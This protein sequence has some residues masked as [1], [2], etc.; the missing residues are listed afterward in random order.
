MIH[1]KP[2][3]PKL[4]VVSSIVI[5][6]ITSCISQKKI[7]YL[8]KQSEN[9]TTS[10]YINKLDLQYK[11]QPKDNLFIKINSL[12]EKTYQF[13]N[14]QGGTSGYLNDFNS[15]ASIYLNSYSVNEEGNIDLPILGKIRVKGLTITEIKDTIQKH[16]DEY[17]KQTTVTVKL[18]NFNITVI[19]EVSRPGE[20]KIYQDR[21]NL[22]EAISLAGDM[23]DYANRSQ[24]QLI[25]Q[26]RSGSKVH[27]L[28]LTSDKILSSEYFYLM[29]NDIVYISPLGLKR[30]GF[31]QF[32]YSTVLTALTALTSLI[33]VIYTIKK[34]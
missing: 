28:D 2:L 5:F 25:R 18:V 19:G 13:F 34:L 12:D 1:S 23:S 30:Y 9:D 21:I 29:P 16:I 24:V 14:K 15:D 7:L 32:P 33:L 26:T 22:F 20:F 11:V 31:T 4:L 17:L 10:E 8:Q 27:Y 6:L 3:S